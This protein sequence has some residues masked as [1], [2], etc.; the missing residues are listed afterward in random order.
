[1][2]FAY[3]KHKIYIGEISF[4]LF[5][6]TG[7]FKPIAWNSKWK[8]WLY[9]A[10]STFMITIYFIFVF[11]ILIYILR[12]AQNLET[13]IETTFQFLALS[14]VF[15]KMISILVQS[16]TAIA[17]ISLFMNKLCQPR[18]TFESKILQQSSH[19]CR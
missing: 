6:L 5:H 10:Y 16:R 18:D 15:F 19:A 14:N 13:K 7:I 2:M 12:L 8:I 1:M 3:N 9:N 11:S 4:L 17:S